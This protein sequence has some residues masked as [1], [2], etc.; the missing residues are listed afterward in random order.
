[1]AAQ[2]LWGDGIMIHVVTAVHN[3]YQITEAFIQCLLKQDYPQIHLLLV[4]DG[5]TDGTADMAKRLLPNTTVI[6]GDGNLWWGGALHEAYKWFKN[7]KTIAD[8]EYVMFANDDTEFA[9]DYISRAIGILKEQKQV[10][11]AGC[12]ISKQTGMQKDGAVVFDFRTTSCSLEGLTEGN[13]ASTRSL[14][15]RVGDFRKIGGFHPILLPHYGSDYEWTIRA[16]R[17]HQYRVVCDLSLQYL[18]NEETTGDNQYAKLTRKKL[19]SKR[20]ISNPLY[21]IS[22][23]LLVTPLGLIP[24]ALGN[25]FRRNQQKADIIK[26]IMRR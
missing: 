6:Q 14:F 10:L 5:S 15:F 1:M 7:E 2:I 26:D 22:Y 8:D 11:L 4:D 18:M 23:I 9:G 25:Q 21:K 13:C 16:C 20:S 3:R 19:M 12:G 17:K 24:T